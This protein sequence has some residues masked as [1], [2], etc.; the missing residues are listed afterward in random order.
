LTPLEMSV[1]DALKLVVS[2]GIV[3]PPYRRRASVAAG[4]PD[5]PK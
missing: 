2:A 3:V 4:E 1:E 5:Q